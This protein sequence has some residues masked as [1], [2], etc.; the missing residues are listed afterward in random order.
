V[1]ER[2]WWPSLGWRL[3]SRFFPLSLALYTNRRSLPLEEPSIPELPNVAWAHVEQENLLNRSEARLRGIESK[4]PGLATSS[5]IVIG[6][7]ALA[8]SQTW[9]DSACVMRALLLIAVIYA[10]ASLVTPVW[11]VGPLARATVTEDSIVSAGDGA[12]A[13]ERLARFKTEA[14]M[15][16]ARQAQRL[17]NL[18]AA[19]RNDLVNAIFVFAV[20]GVLTLLDVG[21]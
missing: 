9:S 3:A 5:A 13:P 14:A 11:L 7:I 16:N 19:S 8:I 2:R 17:A 12:S 6:V 18:Q 21:K 20:W 4:G 10:T 15:V 1:S